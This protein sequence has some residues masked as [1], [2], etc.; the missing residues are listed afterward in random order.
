MRFGIRLPGPFFATFGRSARG[1]ARR[2]LAV[3]AHEQRILAEMEQRARV[4]REFMGDAERFA[5]R[6]FGGRGLFRAAAR[7][8]VGWIAL[9]GTRPVLACFI[10]L[11]VV[12]IPAAL[13]EGI[14]SSVR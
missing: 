2:N 6:R 10:A 11:V 5:H 12:G 1:Q 9:F 14:V 3:R 4:D 7:Y 8:V 13:I